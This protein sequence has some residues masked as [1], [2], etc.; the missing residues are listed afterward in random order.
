MQDQQE[1]MGSRESKL[2]IKQELV[3]IELI[4][5]SVDIMFLW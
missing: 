1:A 3:R 5:Q 4:N 2:H